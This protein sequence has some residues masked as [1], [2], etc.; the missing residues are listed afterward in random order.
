MAY[1]QLVDL[2]METREGICIYM[3]SRVVCIIE[4]GCQFDCRYFYFRIYLQSK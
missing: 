3:R 4:N 2:A 1:S